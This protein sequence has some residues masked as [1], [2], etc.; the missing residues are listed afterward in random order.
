MEGNFITY[1]FKDQTML[2]NAYFN[3]LEQKR[4]NA[5]FNRE[6][7]SSIGGLAKSGEMV[8]YPGYM[9]DGYEFAE[10]FRNLG[11][12]LRT[13]AI[14]YEN[15]ENNWVRFGFIT[16]RIAEGDGGPGELLE[17]NGRQAFFSE[18]VNHG[19][20]FNQLAIYLGDG[21]RFPTLIVNSD[22]LD[23]DE[24]IKIAENMELVNED[25][26]SIENNP[27]Y[28]VN[29]KDKRILDYAD[30][31]MRNIKSGNKEFSFKIDENTEFFKRSQDNTCNISYRNTNLHDIREYLYTPLD[32]DDRIL[33]GYNLEFAQVTGQPY[34]ASKNE[35]Y[36][37]KKGDNRLTIMMDVIGTTSSYTNKVDALLKNIMS[38]P[39]CFI[40]QPFYGNSDQ[41]Y[42]YLNIDDYKE[43]RTAFEEDGYLYRVIPLRR[44]NMLV[45]LPTNDLT[46][47]ITCS[48]CRFFTAII[49]RSAGGSVSSGVI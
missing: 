25:K 8:V 19:N 11:S 14:S 12:N 31:Y 37:F 43:I 23:K 6:Y 2:Y 9:P 15:S 17:I 1:G 41:L 22:V 7:F 49:K 16:G 44:D 26:N 27:D 40:Y 47:S 28:F 21:T 46:V 3:E 42:Y 48:K 10:C 4:T 29:I 36:H 24:I 32:I 20:K 35:S 45:F 30:E 18:Q 34:A 33:D 39:Y 38:S 13:I 5:I